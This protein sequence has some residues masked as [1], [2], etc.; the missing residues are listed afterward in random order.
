MTWMQ[1]RS[2]D[3]GECVWTFHAGSRSAS[4]VVHLHSRDGGAEG[5]DTGGDQGEG[6]PGEECLDCWE[7]LLSRYCQIMETDHCVGNLGN[8][9]KRVFR[10]LRS[11]PSRYCQIMETD[12]CV[13]NVGNGEKRVLRFIISREN[14]KVKFNIGLLSD[15]DEHISFEFGLMIETS[16]LYV[17]KPFWMTLT[18]V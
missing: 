16:K 12:Y 10:L 9:E 2:L 7:S 5:G 11:L 4:G 6:C 8:G 3:G 15:I 18:F 13:G 17:L 14:Y 1:A